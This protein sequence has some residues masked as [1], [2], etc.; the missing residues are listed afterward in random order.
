MFPLL[1]THSLFINNTI[2]VEPNSIYGGNPCINSLNSFST[3]LITNAIFQ[4][5]QAFD[6]SNC[7]HFNGIELHLNDSLFEGNRFVSNDPYIGNSGVLTLSSDEFLM[8]NVTI[9]RNLAFKATGILFKNS[10]GHHQII[11]CEKVLINLNDIYHK[12][13]N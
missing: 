9:I 12:T 11:H 3:L 7:I 4:N 6:Q 1:L 13:L 5:N 8:F 2:N 10:N